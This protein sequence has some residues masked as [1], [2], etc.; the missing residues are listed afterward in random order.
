M[1]ALSGVLET[2]GICGIGRV[3]AIFLPLI[4]ETGTAAEVITLLKD[5]G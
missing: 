1:T 3:T 5:R 2:Y 4:G